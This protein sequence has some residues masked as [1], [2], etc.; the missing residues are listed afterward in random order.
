MDRVLISYTNLRTDAVHEEELPVDLIIAIFD[1]TKGPVVHS[2]TRPLA[3]SKIAASMFPA[4][5]QHNAHFIFKVSEFFVYTVCILPKNL[6]TSRGNLQIS[7]GLAAHKPSFCQKH[8][9][10]LKR[11]SEV[12]TEARSLQIGSLTP[13]LTELN[14][15]TYY[16]PIVSLM[17]HPFPNLVPRVTA[18]SQ[19]PGSIV[20][21]WKARL[22]GLRILVTGSGSL[23]EATQLAYLAAV[24]GCPFR[25]ITECCFHVSLSDA[26]YLNEGDWRVA[27]VTHP[28]LETTNNYDAKLTEGRISFK[29]QFKWIERGH[30]ELYDWVA[31][32]VSRRN[33]QGVITTLIN[34]NQRLQNVIGNSDLMTVSVL[35]ELGINVS[36][37]DFIESFV[38]SQK[39]SMKFEFGCC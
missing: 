10:F 36:D 24:V 38:L 21:L 39:P 9:E 8:F 11:A 29:S 37:K 27:A 13:I 15:S 1:S 2:S 23:Q 30:G 16:S 3:K 34:F 7:V 6:F 5:W 33:P 18:F 35:D 12:I 4:K 17:P 28:I 25:E 20:K 26:L 19:D 14:I 31:G 22:L 32:D